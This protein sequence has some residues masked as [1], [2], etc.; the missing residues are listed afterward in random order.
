MTGT[1]TPHIDILP[2]AQQRLRPELRP[3]AALGF[4][5]YR[6]TAIALRPGHR[7]SVDFDFFSEPALDHAAL[8][9]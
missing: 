6:G 8:Q 5:L 2:A 9:T 7:L 1:L 4:A 3:A